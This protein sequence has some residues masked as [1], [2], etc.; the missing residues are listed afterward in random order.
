MSTYL[1]REWQSQNPTNST[2]AK[3]L[4]KIYQDYYEPEAKKPNG[5]N[6]RGGGK[7][8]RGGRGGRAIGRR[9]A[10]VQPM[11]VVPDPNVSSI[12]QTEIEIFPAN[13]SR[14]GEHFF[15]SREIKFF[16]YFF[17]LF[18]LSHFF[19]EFYR[20]TLKRH[21]KKHSDPILGK[22]H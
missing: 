10:N 2:S 21:I 4:Y 3:D 14:K 16:M 12:P 9:N 20:K 13:I 5:N 6:L 22:L 18:H 7:P 8:N 17:I 1:H 11:M 15:Q 19:F